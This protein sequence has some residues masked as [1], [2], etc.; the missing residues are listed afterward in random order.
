MK[1]SQGF[2]FLEILVAMIVLAIGLFG[3]AAMQTNGLKSTLQAYNN[4]QASQLAYD[5]IDRMRTNIA[6]SRN[7]VGANTYLDISPASAQEYADCA[8]VANACSATQMAEQDL[9]LWH[10]SITGK[11]PQGTGIISFVDPI[12]TISVQWDA[13][14]DGYI[15]NADPNFQLSFVI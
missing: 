14:R 7:A 11:L 12:F 3:M 13:N 5:L 15:T 2:T 1:T 4:G 9:F 6:V 8:Q 10:Q